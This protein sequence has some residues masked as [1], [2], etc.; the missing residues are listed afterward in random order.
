M[1]ISELLDHWSRVREGLLATARKFSNA[2][3]E[4]VPF[5]NGYAVAQLLLHIAHE[6][7][8]EVQYGILREASEMPP[9]FSEAE[10]DTLDKIE[11]VLNETH[12]RT[13]RFLQ[14]LN[15]EDMDREIEA[16]WGARGT[17]S[18]FLWHVLEHEIHHRGELSLLLGLLGKQGLDA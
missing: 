2:D 17:L 15:D 5:P 7:A 18:D 12:T 3:I 8:I 4:Y 16:P 10:Y 11:A 14:T 9:A 1:K 13:E 6:E